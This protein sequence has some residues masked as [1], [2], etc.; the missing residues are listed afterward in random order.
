MEITARLAIR[1]PIKFTLIEGA[2]LRKEVMWFN[3]Y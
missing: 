1:L 2:F 3:E